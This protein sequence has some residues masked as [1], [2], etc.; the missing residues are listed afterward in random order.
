MAYPDPSQ[1]Q[2]LTHRASVDLDAQ[3]VAD[4]NVAAFAKARLPYIIS[5][6]GEGNVFTCSTDEG[7]ERFIQ[8][9]RVRACWF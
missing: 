1:G 2:T 9:Y 8:R 5:T 7:M 4:A 6:G 3:A